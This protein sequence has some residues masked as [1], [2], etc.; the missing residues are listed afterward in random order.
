ML[1]KR[2]V[3]QGAGVRCSP[4]WKATHAHAHQWVDVGYRK[5][6]HFFVELLD[7]SG[8]VFQADLEDL[9]V[10]NLAYANKVE[11]RVCEV[12]A[13]RQFLYK[14]LRA[15]ASITSRTQ[16]CQLILPKHDTYIEMSA[17]EAGK[18]KRQIEHKLL[19]PRIAFCE[20]LLQV[21]WQWDG[22]WNY[23]KRFCEHE[24]QPFIIV[25]RTSDLQ[26]ANLRKALQGHIAKLWDLEEPRQ[27]RTNNGRF[28]YISQRDPIQKS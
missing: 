20:N 22:L 7:K 6:L 13:I 19:V 21:H 10:I 23:G 25:V 28:E 27:Q 24:H 3:G 16:T 1:A 14:L 17:E 15:S 11:V 4:I 8:P 18:E 5:L 9:S 2:I 12:V 26:A